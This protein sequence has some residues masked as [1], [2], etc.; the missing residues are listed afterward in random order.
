MQA[1]DVMQRHLVTVT[2]TDTVEHA[3]RMMLEHRVSGLAV[4]DHDGQLVGVVTEGD[5]LHRVE[6]DTDRL[7]SLLEQT[8]TRPARLKA[9]F[10]KATGSEVKDVMTTSVVTVDEATLLA[11]IAELFDRC[12]IKRVPV[13]RDGKLVGI[14]SR[15]DLL[16]A[17]IGSGSARP[18]DLRVVDFR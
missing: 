12:R 1:V 11:D 15:A 18:G 3:A 7:H 9:E 13:M 4:V 2:P 10:V 14:V 8:F 16:R 5:L 17:L 6:N